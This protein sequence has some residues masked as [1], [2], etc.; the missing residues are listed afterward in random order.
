MKKTVDIITIG[1]SEYHYTSGYFTDNKWIDNETLVL[2]RA[3]SESIGD[4]RDEPEEV[5]LV[6]LSLK[7]NSMEVILKDSVMGYN[8]LV[9]GDKIY[10]SDRKNLKVMDINTKEKETLYTVQ[11]GARI[12]GISITTDGAVIGMVIDWLDAPEKVLILDAKSG[13]VKDEF[14]HKFPDPFWNVCHAMICPTNPDLM[15]FCH[16]GR[17][18]YVSNRMWLHDAKTGKDWNFA[19]QRMDENGNLIDCFGHE[20]WAPNGKGMYFVK[21][22]VSPSKPTGICYVDAETSKVDLLYTGYK[23][24][25]IGVSQDGK[26]L[27]GDTLLSVY[28]GDGNSEVVVIDLE[29]DSESVVDVVKISGQHPCHPHPQMSPEN[30]KVCYTALDE[31]GR[32]VTKIAFLK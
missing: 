12:Y 28:D 23:Y 27:A 3:K 25:H 24:W 9:F 7:D 17:T 11:G 14:S 4:K 6:K 21:Y 22:P 10:Y 5:E 18:E 32:T 2:E 30:D 31:N 19:K 20:M 1:D 15:Y 26:Y 8:Y 13:V 16:E 29:D